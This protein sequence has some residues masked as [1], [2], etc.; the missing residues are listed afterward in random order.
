MHGPASHVAA[1]HVYVIGNL[2][3]SNSPLDYPNLQ[4]FVGTIFIIIEKMKYK[5]DLNGIWN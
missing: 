3:E 4:N 2:E 1:Q 5:V